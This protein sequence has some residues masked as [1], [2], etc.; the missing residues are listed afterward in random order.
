MWIDHLLI[1]TGGEL[2]ACARTRA[3]ACVLEGGYAVSSDDACFFRIRQP[4]NQ[5]ETLLWPHFR[6]HSY[7][8]AALVGVKR[9]LKVLGLP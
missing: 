1:L 4:R 9:G 5:A 3:R 6:P 2:L 7:V 8:H